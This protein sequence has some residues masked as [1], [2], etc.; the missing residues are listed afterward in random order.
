MPMGGRKSN[1]QLKHA[2]AS[3]VLKLIYDLSGGSVTFYGN[4]LVLVAKSLFSVGTVSDG[5]ARNLP[6]VS[7][8]YYPVVVYSRWKCWADRR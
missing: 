4:T 3:N 6:L 8:Y 2:V 5:Q 7:E 1:S